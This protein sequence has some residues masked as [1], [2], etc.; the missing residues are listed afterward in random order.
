MALQ[1]PCTH[2]RTFQSETETTTVEQVQEDGSIIEVEVPVWEDR[3]ET[4]EDIYIFVKQI[5]HFT[6][7][8]QNEDKVRVVHFQIAGYPTQEHRDIDQ[9]GHILWDSIELMNY[10]VDENVYTQIYNQLKQMDGFTQLT[11]C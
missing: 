9:E 5:T 8:P 2:T 1:G 6:I 11:D 4:Y 10:N 7:Y 3:T